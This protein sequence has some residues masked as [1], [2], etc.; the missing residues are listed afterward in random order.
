MDAKNTR[1]PFLEGE[2]KQA[3]FNAV[4]KKIRNNFDTGKKQL[5][6]ISDVEIKQLNDRYSHFADTFSGG[7]LVHSALI[8][9]KLNLPKGWFHYFFNLKQEIRNIAVSVVAQDGA[10]VLSLDSLVFGSISKLNTNE[11]YMHVS[12]VYRNTRNVWVKNE[13]GQAYL[14][15]PQPN[16]YDSTGRLEAEIYAAFSGEQVPGY[17]VIR[18][19]RDGLEF[20][21][22]IFVPK[23]LP[24]E[25]CSIAVKNGSGVKRSIHIYQEIN[26]GLDSHPSHYFVG[27]A[28]SEVD[29]DAEKHAIL[30]KNLD[31][32]NSFPRWAALISG[33][34]PASFESCGDL[35]Y[36]F[37]ATIIY[38][39]AIFKEKLSNV[40]AKQPLKG[41]VGVFQYEFELEP[42]E[43]REISLALVAI[44]PAVGVDQQINDWKEILTQTGAEAELENVNG[45][46]DRMF[47]SYLIKTPVGEIDRTF[48]VWGKYQSTLCSRF[49]SPYDVGTRDMFQYLLA[50]CVFEPGYV[51]MMIPYLL[52]YQYRNGRIPRQESKFS[53]L[54]DLRS[55]MDCQLWMH[56]LVS[57]YIQES[58]DFDILDEEVGFLEADHKTRSHKDKEPIY[59]HLLLAIKSAYEGNLGEHGLC[60]LGYGGWNDAL[61]GLKGEHSE[62]VWLSQLL[63]YASRKMR[64]LAEWKKDQD[65]V[66]YLDRLI[67]GVTEA[68]NISGWDKQGYYI[69][70]YDNQGRPV[71]S[72]ANDEGQKHL[73]ENSWAIL[74]GVAPQERISSITHAM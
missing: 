15:N 54:N 20:R 51:R 64:E 61:D 55:F 58:G 6:G 27:M 18:S 69:F 57:L 19:S 67:A 44:D 46:W 8:I 65:T 41:M 49:N 24:G 60:K 73:N 43:E 39:A 37:G 13:K 62:S 7:F 33:E 23:G 5:E 26:F 48:N 52:S 29:Y 21:Y 34:K 25:I 66:L 10:G 72:S 30:A 40:E 4:I 1:P 45:L 32:K 71:G 3:M 74:S 56:D 63:V 31:V 28:V 59:Q 68:I 42:A 35:Y 11:N 14:L 9:D 2:E 12:Q 36:G 50:N 47:E 17:T 38:P 53:E 70:G 16:F 22:R